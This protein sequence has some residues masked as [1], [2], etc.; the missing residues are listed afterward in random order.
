MSHSEKRGQSS[1]TR[2]TVSNAAEMGFII[3]LEAAE[4]AWVT[5]YEALKALDQEQQSFHRA[6][7]PKTQSQAH[8]LFHHL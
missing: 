6:E 1:E 8:C 3:R 2:E 7:S 4:L 5:G